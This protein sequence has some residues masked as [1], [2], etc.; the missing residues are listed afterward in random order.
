MAH[1]Q[2]VIHKLTRTIFTKELQITFASNE[3]KVKLFTTVKFTMP[4]LDDLEQSKIV[5]VERFSHSDGMG[6]IVMGRRFG[7]SDEK[8]TNVLFAIIDK[9]NL[10]NNPENI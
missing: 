3:K 7:Y 6:W 5:R 1:P 4:M 2:V 9:F 10:N 8:F